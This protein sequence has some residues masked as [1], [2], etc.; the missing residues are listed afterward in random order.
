SARQ[1]HHEVI[2]GQPK[3][4]R[5]PLSDLDRGNLPRPLHLP[6]HRLHQRLKVRNRHRLS[7]L[8]CGS[9]TLHPNWP[10]A[11]RRPNPRG[12]TTPI[13]PSRASISPPSARHR[14]PHLCS[15]CPSHPSK[16]PP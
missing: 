5:K 16:P 7:D 13:E 10:S 8:Y 15:T 11:N 6:P 2:L 12:R 1:H 14:L 3:T 9:P 4:G